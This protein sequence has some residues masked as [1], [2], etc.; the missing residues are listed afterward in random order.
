MV[1]EAVVSFLTSAFHDYKLEAHSFHSLVPFFTVVMLFAVGGYFSGFFSFLSLLEF[2]KENQREPTTQ[3][4]RVRFKD[5]LFFSIGVVNV[6]LSTFIVGVAPSKYYIFFTL[7]C[8]LLLGVR[9]ISYRRDGRQYL[10]W[11]FCYWSNFLFLLYVW[12]WDSRTVFRILFVVANGPLAWSVV[13]FSNRTVFHNR[14]QMTSLFI[15]VSPMLLSYC[16]RWN[17]SA[18]DVCEGGAL[19]DCWANPLWLFLGALLKCYVIWLVLYYVWVFIILG[20]RAREKKYKTMFDWYTSEGTGQLINRFHPN[21]LVN[22][23]LYCMMHC[24]CSTIALFL[25]SLLWN[26]H[27]A[28]FSFIVIINLIGIW[29][30][31]EHYFQ[32]FAQ[33][34][35]KD[36]LLKLGLTATSKQG[37]LDLNH[38]EPAIVTT[39]K[40]W[41]SARRGTDIQ[42]AD[43]PLHANL[44]RELGLNSIQISEIKGL[45]QKEFKVGEVNLSEL[46][47][48]AHV[49]AIA[50]SRGGTAKSEKGGE[51]EVAP[52]QWNEKS[53]LQPSL[54]SDLQNIPLAFSQ[55]A[56]RFKKHVAIADEMSGVLTFK[57]L[58][59]SAS[60][61]ADHII[62]N[63]ALF[64]G[65]RIGLM[66][67]ACTPTAIVLLALWFAK[68]VP[69][70]VNWTSGSRNIKSMVDSSD[71]K[72]VIT[73]RSFLQRLGP[74]ELGPLHEKGVL[75]FLEDMKDGLFYA[76]I[77][78]NILFLHSAAEK[79]DLKSI[80]P[81]DEAVILFTSGSESAPKGVPLTHMNILSL[82]RGVVTMLPVNSSDI[83]LA[84]LPPFHSFGFTCCIVYP[85]VSGIKTVY[86][87][88]PTDYIG[89]SKQITKWRPTIYM[90]TPTFLSGVLANTPSEDTASLKYCITGAEKTPQSLFDEVARRR[91]VPGIIEGYG[92]TECS[93][94]LTLNPPGKEP[95]GVGYPVPGVEMISVAV[96][97]FMQ[98]RTIVP[99][100]PGQEGLLLCSGTSIFSG[101]LGNTGIDAFVMYNSKRYYITGDLGSIRADGAVF[102]SG[103][104][105]RVKVAGEMIS[106]GAVEEALRQVWPNTKEGISVAVE[107]IEK[108][109]EQPQI[110]VFSTC[111][112]TRDQAAAVLRAAGLPNI[113]HPTVTLVVPEIPLLGS[114]KANYPQLKALLAKHL[115]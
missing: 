4:A 88:A 67:P 55:C 43:I 53:R 36:L 101:Y 86:Y 76:N 78:K 30:G 83:I 94:I 25:G 99:Q 18:F 20:P 114:G 24:V 107:A 64:P 65:R 54:P 103:R 62:A 115:G 7:K 39:V 13:A 95:A 23:L 72:V 92:I 85:L 113:A 71:L 42:A 32:S 2:R 59:L 79:Y 19:N 50:S 6:A 27:I 29:Q 70:M 46:E 8:C 40:G 51:K 28:H 41:V 14:E 34:Y 33:S 35:E 106:L 12:F 102:L 74:V 77:L 82:L 5:K 57:K 56:S 58:Q 44:T 90:G 105:K 17:P 45:L 26:S 80:K 87:P 48:V 22:K 108:A 15:H 112:V 37:A 81:Q 47:T 98:N 52:E 69:V 31:A 93:P 89:I 68:K 100:K 10:F 1:F 73:S 61:F 9:Y 97:P 111:G 11:D 91:I 63:P 16:L 110:C 75:V 49:A 84:S 21:H 66:L 3:I 96:E 104:L 109:G 60:L 38:L